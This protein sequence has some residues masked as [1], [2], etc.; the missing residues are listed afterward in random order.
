MELASGIGK[1]EA[2]P[3]RQYHPLVTLDRPLMTLNR[4]RDPSKLHR[5][6]TLNCQSVCVAEDLL[7]GSFDITKGFPEF[8][9]STFGALQWTAGQLIPLGRVKA[10]NSSFETQ[11]KERLNSALKRAENTGRFSVPFT[12]RM[13]RAWTNSEYIQPRPILHGM[14]TFA[15]PNFTSDFMYVQNVSDMALLQRSVAIIE[16]AGLKGQADEMLTRIAKQKSNVER[17]ITMFRDDN[18]QVAAGSARTVTV[19]A[20]P[21][22]LA[23]ELIREME[24]VPKVDAARAEDTLQDLNIQDS[25]LE[26]SL[27][28]PPEEE[29]MGMEADNA[30]AALVVSAN[31]D[32][33][34]PALGEPPQEPK[35]LTDV[36]T[37]LLEMSKG[38]PLTDP[39]PNVQVFNQYFS[40]K[41]ES[42]K[43]LRKNRS[44][45]RGRLMAG[46]LEASSSNEDTVG[47]GATGAGYNQSENNK[48]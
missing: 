17:K 16:R 48:V 45:G 35:P 39:D 8:L 43:R 1:V 21:Q 30:I 44:T 38:Q 31:Y 24:S 9:V 29:P 33:E 41:V 13:F 20:D 47:F 18:G 27:G 40:K 36:Q 2:L 14:W 12:V 6:F 46:A 26:E 22:D 7:L 32:V 10:A 25:V 34:F 42:N 37:N 28:H 4:F 23:Q 11:L 15:S 19:N 3:L 5:K